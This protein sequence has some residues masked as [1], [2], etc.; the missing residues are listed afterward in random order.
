MVRI[1]SGGVFLSTDGGASWKTGITGHGINTSY[2]TA[3]QINANEINILS[4]AFP[5]FRWDSMGLNAYRFEIGN[6][7]KPHSFNT[8]KFVR[9]D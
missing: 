6:D 2:L 9:F 4:G 5:S 8:A 7:E 3:G 1:I